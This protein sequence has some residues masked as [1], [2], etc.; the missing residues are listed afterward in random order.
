MCIR[1][2]PLFS[3]DGALS[4]P[5]ITTSNSAYAGGL[6]LGES[7]WAA[8]WNF[9]LY[10]D[11][12]AKAAWFDIVGI[13]ADPAIDTDTDGDGVVDLLDAFPTLVGE[14]LDTDGDG[15]GN[16]TDS[17]DDGDGILDAKDAYPLVSL[18]ALPDLD[19]DGRPN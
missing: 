16:N 8:E 1:D 13:D 3:I 12:R 18:V 19:G 7:D 17:D 11:N 6:N 5:A 2:R 4:E 9:G 15:V 14:T 10:P